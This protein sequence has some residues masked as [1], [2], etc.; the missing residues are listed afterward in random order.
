MIADTQ[1]AS[2][3]SVRTPSHAPAPGELGDRYVLGNVIGRGGMGEIRLARDSRIH[4]DVAVK[5]VRGGPP[6]EHELERFFREAR[7]QGVLEHPSVVPVHDLGIDASGSPYFVMK[8]L[9]GITLADV[10]SA[11]APEIAARWPRRQLLARFVDICLAIDFAHARGVIHRDLK[12]ANIMLGDYGEAYVLDWGLARVTNDVDSLAGVARVPAIETSDATGTQTQA[13]VLLGTPGYMSPEQARGESV[14]R[15]TDVFALGMV[16][17]EI[18]AGAPAVARGAGAIADTLAAECHRPGARA[19]D[20]APELDDLCARATAAARTDRPTVRQLADGVQAYLDGDRDLARRRELA[21]VHA[22]RAE[23]ALADRSDQARATAMREAGRALALDPEN[24]SAAS[25]LGGLLIDAPEEIPAEAIAAADHERDEV[26][27][28]SLVRATTMYLVGAAITVTLFIAPLRHAWPVVFGICAQL[29]AALVAWF[30]ARRRLPMVSPWF[31]GFMLANNFVI[32]SV[33]LMFGPLLVMPIF[34]V[35][36]LSAFLSQP[37]HHRPV[38]IIAVGLIPVAALLGLELLGVLPRSFY[39][40]HADLVI[41]PYTMDMTPV[42]LG[43]LL[44]LAYAIQVASSADIQLKLRHEQQ[45]AQ[46]R[47]HAQ[48]WH[49]EQLLPVRKKLSK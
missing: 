23:A 4:R 34:I 14:D 17:Y 7:V 12:P 28:K 33:G 29:G 31:Y 10:L 38:A 43:V 11:T 9:A 5:L 40:E 32:A 20:V 6:G 2:S 8:R 24:A 18:L 3:G 48:R 49:L 21:E 42:S 39:I 27:R 44:S 41:S 13:G 16:L 15:A 45:L 37:T 26:R 30:L 22:G 1:P 35:G 46:D 19:A 25:V 36:S 47:L